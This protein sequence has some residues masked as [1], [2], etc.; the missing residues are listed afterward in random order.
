MWQSSRPASF[1]PAGL[2]VW[3]SWL[4][5]WLATL[6]W[7]S[8]KVRIPVG[9]PEYYSWLDWFA[10]L[11]FPGLLTGAIF[12]SSHGNSF[13]DR[14]PVDFIYGCPIFKWVVKS[15]LPTGA[16]A[17]ALPRGCR[18][19]CIICTINVDSKWPFFLIPRWFPRSPTICHCLDTVNILFI[20]QDRVRMCT[21]VIDGG[22]NRQRPRCDLVA[23][24]S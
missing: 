5:R 6:G 24:A 12:K 1:S 19:T 3:P 7:L 14:A 18:V 9:L 22:H 8:V 16:V 21:C 23:L 20:V 13:E 2:T 17:P 11:S 15:W 4:E 10:D